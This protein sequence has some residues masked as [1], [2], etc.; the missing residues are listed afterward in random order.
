VLLVESGSRHLFDRLIPTIYASYGAD[1]VID[2]VTCY[3]GAPAGLDPAKSTIFRVTDYSGV[4]GRRRLLK[5]LRARHYTIT[6]IICSAEPIMAKWKWYLALGIPAKTFALNE[7]GDYFWFDR[8]HLGILAHFALYR[9]GLTGAGAIPT[10]GRLLFF[11]FTVVYLVL[12]AGWVHLKRAMR[13]MLRRTG[14]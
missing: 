8:G 12:F 10:L 4:Q 7:N 3:G 1:I 9:A 14:D 13:M 11:P 6:G 5:E 2:L